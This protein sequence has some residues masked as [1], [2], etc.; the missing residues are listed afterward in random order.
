MARKTPETSYRR[1]TEMLWGALSTMANT[2]EKRA[3]IVVM[4]MNEFLT[5]V[6]IDEAWRSAVSI[7]FQDWRFYPRSDTIQFVRE[8]IIEEAKLDKP[9]VQALQLF[10]TLT[11][12][13]GRPIVSW[14]FV[15]K[16]T[17]LTFTDVI[18]AA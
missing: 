17:L 16:R 9:F 1:E 10:R 11:E 15:I 4:K 5:R 2:D 13:D 12:M 7:W 14:H 3:A 18:T 6:K 8:I